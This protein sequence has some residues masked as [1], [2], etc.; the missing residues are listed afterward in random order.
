MS[1]FI[2]AFSLLPSKQL[3]CHLKRKLVISNL[4]YLDYVICTKKIICAKNL[5]LQLPK[6]AQERVGPL[7]E[8]SRLV[9]HGSTGA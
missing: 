5:L 2:A 8:G 3:D 6:L 1:D 4:K 9:N 7:E